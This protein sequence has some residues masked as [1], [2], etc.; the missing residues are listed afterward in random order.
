M[1]TDIHLLRQH[2]DSICFSISTNSYCLARS[3]L[4]ISIHLSPPVSSL[5]LYLP[6][7]LGNLA[8]LVYRKDTNLCYVVAIYFCN[9]EILHRDR[10]DIDGK[11]QEYGADNIYFLYFCKTD[12]RVVIIVQYEERCL[13]TLMLES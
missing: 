4:D 1:Q 9:L 10:K 7:S 13:K 2:S 12:R 8:V 6:S 5:A 3:G 11:L